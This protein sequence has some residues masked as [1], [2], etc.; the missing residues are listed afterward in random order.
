MRVPEGLERLLSDPMVCSSVYQKH[1]KQHDMSSDAASLGIVDF[2]RNF[3]TYLH[4]LNI[5]EA[6]IVSDEWLAESVYLLDI[7][8]G[9]VHNR[10]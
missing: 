2:K 8:R 9:C 3:R 10:E 5:E 4:A 7:M 1:A 6:E